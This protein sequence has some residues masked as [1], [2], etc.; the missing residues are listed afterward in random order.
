MIDCAPEILAQIK[1]VTA[2]QPRARGHTRRDSP[3]HSVL[4]TNGDIDHVAGALS[5]RERQPFVLNATAEI[6]DVLHANS[7][8]AV[9]AE[10]VVKRTTVELDVPFT[11]VDGVEARVFPVPGKAALY[12]EGDQVEI[13][14]E[15]EATV[16]VE[17]ISDGASAYY[18]PGCAHM[19][20]ALA[21]R[22]R[23][24]AVVV[25]DGTLWHDEEM[26]EAG[27]GTKTGPR[28][29]HMAMSGDHGS[30]A[31]FASI[32]VGRRIYSHINNTNP[33]LIEGSPERQA[34]EA[35]GWEIA[36]DGMEIEL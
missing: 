34:A 18:V 8:F 2:L 20:E 36:H 23:G 7:V 25:F 13:G 9:L 26:I 21:N 28:M 24:A 33:V 30:M 29:G 31:A 22:L 10:D 12:L 3:I 16:G 32:D 6:H 1:A 11:L 27:V 15:G 14:G 35:A 19:S 17:F 4:L 5:L